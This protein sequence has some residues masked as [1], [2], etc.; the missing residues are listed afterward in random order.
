[1]QVFAQVGIDDRDCLVFRHG[2]L[3]GFAVHSGLIS[4]QTQYTKWDNMHIKCVLTH[5]PSLERWDSQGQNG[6]FLVLLAWPWIYFG[7][8]INMLNSYIEEVVKL[9]PRCVE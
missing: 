1:M 8:H 7:N 2:R 3:C 6:C 9:F 5:N 4:L